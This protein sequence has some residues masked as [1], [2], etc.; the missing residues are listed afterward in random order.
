[1]PRHADAARD[2]PRLGDFSPQAAA[3][4]RSRPSYPAPLLEQLIQHVGAAPGA[5]VA[6]IGAG[7]GLWTQ[8]LAK[9]GF[10]V[11][12]IDPSAGMQAQA[13]DDANVR[14][15]AGTFERTGLPDG[16]QDWVTAAQ[17]FHWALPEQ[18]LPEL[19]RVLRRNGFF[20]VLWNNRHEDAELLSWT[21]EAIRRHI[22]DYESSYRSKRDWARELVSTGDFGDVVEHAVDHVIP[23]SAERFVDLWRSQNRLMVTAGPERMA[24]FVAGLTDHLESQNIKTIEVTYTCRAYT[25]RRR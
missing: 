25:A 23:F 2:D 10:K 20:T 13:I 19:R 14:W 3:Y 17:A 8:L 12:A 22:P 4:A 24:N 5:S 18:A 9:R 15:Q 21:R 16:S 7:T 11:T 1:M 6:D